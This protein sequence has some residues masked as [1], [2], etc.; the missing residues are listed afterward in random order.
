MQDVHA[1]DAEL[2]GLVDHSL[3]EH[4]L[5]PQEIREFLPAFRFRRGRTGNEFELRG[6]RLFRNAELQRGASLLHATV[7]EGAEEVIEEDLRFAF[8][9]AL[10]RTREGGELCGGGLQFSRGH[11]RRLPDDRDRARM[12]RVLRRRR[13]AGQGTARGE[14]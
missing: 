8:L 2:R 6:A 13:S 9:V 12:A 11:R 1:L 4:A 5:G 7:A 3:D 14:N 10:Q